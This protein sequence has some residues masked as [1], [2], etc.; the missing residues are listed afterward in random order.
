MYLSNVYIYV[1]THMLFWPVARGGRLTCVDPQK[2]P[3][4]ETRGRHLGPLSVGKGLIGVSSSGVCLG[5]CSGPGLFSWAKR[6][7][8][9][10]PLHLLGR[11]E[12]GP[13]VLD[14]IDSLGSIIF[15]EAYVVWGGWA[16]AW[17]M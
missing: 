5:E 13:G 3:R 8:P 9:R 11:N 1:F 6:T 2:D 12:G 17:K 10:S 4:A 7:A 14:F 16:K 15:S